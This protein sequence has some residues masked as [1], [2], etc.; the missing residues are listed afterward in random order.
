M[1]KNLSVLTVMLRKEFRQFF[2]NPFLPRLCV[3]FPLMVMLV[4][5]LVTDMEVKHIGVVMI[6]NDHSPF[7]RRLAADIN[8]S[9]YLGL[10]AVT[11]T[12]T[13]ALGDVERGHADVIVSI[14]QGFYNSLSSH[15]PLTLDLSANAVNATKGAMGLQ[16]L[17]QVISSALTSDQAG[18]VSAP[19]A[20]STL[21]LFNPTLNYRHFMIP[22]LMIMLI[23]MICGFLPALNIVGEKEKGTI[24]QINVSPIGQLTFTLG[25]I[26]PYWIIGLVVI[27]IGIVIAR[28]VY[29]LSTQGG[30][31]TIYC[32]TALFIVVMSS[33]AVILANFSDNMQQVMFVMFFFVMVFIL[34]SGLMTPVQSMPGW[35]QKVTCVIPPRYYVDIMRATYL[36]GASMADQLPSFSMLGLFALFLT[37][38]A[39]LSY[40]KQN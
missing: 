25:K 30:L 11:A 7:S 33:M 4:M 24:E 14:P 10:Y 29:G 31:S 16:Y 28:L 9:E 26:I 38:V 22:A 3:M 32:A 34:M 15:T 19:V 17:N 27:T 13:E 8:A 5:P 6:D 12:Y 1:M 20:V 37:L 35:A 40:K 23:V 36:R 18:A 2:R 39:I 21:N